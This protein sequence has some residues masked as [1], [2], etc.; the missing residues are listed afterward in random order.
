MA[1]LEKDDGFNIKDVTDL[2]IIAAVDPII[3]TLAA[4]DD[5][6]DSLRL[7]ITGMVY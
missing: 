5:Q 7:R 2:D 3:R 1:V 4:S 6:K